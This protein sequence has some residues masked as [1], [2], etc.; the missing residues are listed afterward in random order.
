[1]LASNNQKFLLIKSLNFPQDQYAITGSGPLGIRGLRS[2]NDID[3][4]VTN[5]LWDKLAQDNAITVENKITKIILLNGLVEIFNENSFQAFS[6]K[7][8]PTVTSRIQEAEIIDGLPF[9]SLKHFIYFKQQY[10]RK[11]DLKDI[12]L[13]KEWLKNENQK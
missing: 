7:E 1:M 12:S 2:I 6:N 8:T 11:K 3:L 13:I 4:I 10:S 9:E 5:P